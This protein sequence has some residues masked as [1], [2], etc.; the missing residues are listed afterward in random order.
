ML[1][2]LGLTFAFHAQDYASSVMRGIQ[3]NFKSLEATAGKKIQGLDNNVKRLG[4]GM[5]AMFG[6]AGLLGLTFSF[7][8]T[9]GEFEQKMTRV[10]DVVADISDA[11]MGKLRALAF[12]MRELAIGPTEAANAIKMLGQAGLNTA[13]ILKTLP[14]AAKFAEAG[15]IKLEDAIILSK[16]LM[17]GYKVEADK[18][19]VAFDQIVTAASATSAD[20]SDFATMLSRGLAGFSGAKVSLTQATAVLGLVRNVMTSSEMSGTA[21]GTMMS[22]ML[23]KKNIGIMQTELGVSSVDSKGQIRETEDIISDVFRRTEKMTEIKKAQFFKTVFGAYG[24]KAFAAIFNQLEQGIRGADQT[25][26][27]GGEGFVHFLRDEIAASANVVGQMSERSLKQFENRINKL[28]SAWEGFE[29]EVGKSFIPWWSKQM[30]RATVAL[31]RWTNEWDKLSPKTKQQIVDW[32]IFGSI[33]LMAVGA[34]MVLGAV[35]PL[36]ATGFELIS[37]AIWATIGSMLPLLVVFGLVAGLVYA[38]RNNVGGLGEAWDELAAKFEDSDSWINGVINWFSDAWEMMRGGFMEVFD[39]MEPVF[40]EIGVAF[41]SLLYQLERLGILMGDNVGQSDFFAQAFHLVGWAIGGVFKF[42]MAAVGGIIKLVAWFFKL[43][44]VGRKVANFFLG[45]NFGPSIVPL[46]PE[47]ARIAKADDTADK[48][49][50]TN[51]VGLGH[52]R[53][54]E[55]LK[56]DFGLYDTWR[57]KRNIQAIGDRDRAKELLDARRAAENDLRDYTPIPNAR[58][59]Y[60]K[61]LPINP[62][63]ASQYSPFQGVQDKP[64]AVIDYEKMALA[65]A[66]TNIALYVDGKRLAETV[67]LHNRDEDIRNSRLGR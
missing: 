66:K 4:G 52:V 64:Q 67:N 13:D 17:S 33:A 1:N 2:G 24:G 49:R 25:V 40:K 45:T 39:G 58:D 56:R 21:G 55:E 18:L 57:S 54:K 36:I 12:E 23:D 60:Y 19:D 28:K 41:H 14:S 30:D 15:E 5:T 37:G 44:D 50:M 59:N 8:R 53:S 20:V 32:T 35:A 22:R 48:D 29:I 10:G 9:A 65:M 46:S 51:L 7:A 3:A 43:I 16:A 38:V 62:A 47:D 31:V 61:P 34:V 11:N 26:R 27:K 63:L 42:A 6:G